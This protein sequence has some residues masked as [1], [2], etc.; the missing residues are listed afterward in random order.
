MWKCASFPDKEPDY[1]VWDELKL[2]HSLA[3]LLGARNPNRFP[4]PCLLPG[5]DSTFL[6]DFAPYWHDTLSHSCFRFKGSTWCE[7]PISPCPKG[8]LLDWLASGGCLSTVNSLSHSRN[9]F[10]MIWATLHLILLEAAIKSCQEQYSGGLWSLR[11]IGWCSEVWSVPGKYP[12]QHHR[13][14]PLTQSNTGP[15]FHVVYA[16]FWPYESEWCNRNRDSSD[17]ATIFQF[18]VVDTCDLL[19]P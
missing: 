14:E 15:C 16:K 9:Q 7:S 12:Q 3:N 18:S 2:I 19:L 11:M 4:F 8:A 6:R 10:E 5:T 13:P 17:Q 1:H